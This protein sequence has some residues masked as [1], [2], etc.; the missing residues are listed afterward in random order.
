MSRPVALVTGASSG[1]GEALAHEFARAGY[2]LVL[3]ARSEARLSEVAGALAGH[4]A[5]A[6]VVAADLR[7]PGAGGAVEAAV[8][9]RSLAVDALV[10]N[11]G[12]GTTGPVLDTPREEQLAMVDVNVRVLTELSHRFGTAMKAR[13]RGGILNVASVAAFQPGPHMAVYY[14]GKAYVLSFSEALN[15]ELRG[16]GVHV[17]CLCPG[18]VATDFQRRASFDDSMRLL[19][20]APPMTAEAVAKAG[21][22]GFRRRKAVVIPGLSNAVMAKSAPFTPRPVLLGI[23]ETLQ[24]KK[25]H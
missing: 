10:N 1:I 23:V 20:V 8:A 4:G 18:P 11:A 6:H 16:S 15:H 25:G 22:E 13:G 17:T 21:F 14:A 12:F 5:T 3:V 2:D 7:D 24:R 9:D 19:K